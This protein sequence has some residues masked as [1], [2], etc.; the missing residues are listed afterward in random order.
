MASSRWPWRLEREAEVGAGLDEVRLEAEDL[1]ECGD[2]LVQPALGEQ[3]RAQGAAG[4]G[5]V[6]E[7]DGFPVLGDGLVQPAPLPECAA[8]VVMNDRAAGRSARATDK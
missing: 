5:V 3:G 6:L 8:E 4:N 2:G 1:A 7:T